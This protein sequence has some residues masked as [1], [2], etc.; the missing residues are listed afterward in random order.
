MGWADDTALNSG[1]TQWQKCTLLNH[2]RIPWSLTVGVSRRDSSTPACRAVCAVTPR[3][4]RTPGV[5]PPD[6][7]IVGGRGAETPLLTVDRS[8]GQI[9]HLWRRSAYA[10]RGCAGAE[11]PVERP[12]GLEPAIPRL[13]GGRPASWAMTTYRLAP[14]PTSHACCYA[15]VSGRRPRTLLLQTAI[16]LGAREPPLPAH[17]QLVSIWPFCRRPSAVGMVT[18]TGIEPVLPP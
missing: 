13:E 14:V 4:P 17:G 5:V 18:R 2:L 8:N 16:M 10:A 15:V 12:A 3:R 9:V 6:R 11:A 1:N 7:D